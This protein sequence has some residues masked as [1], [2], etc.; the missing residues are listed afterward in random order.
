MTMDM[1]LHRAAQMT[2]KWEWQDS[3]G[4]VPGGGWALQ[5]VCFY[6]DFGW[7][8]SQRSESEVLLSPSSLSCQGSTAYGF[9]LGPEDPLQQKRIYRKLGNL[10]TIQ[11]QG[12]MRA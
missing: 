2:L 12:L 9:L 11:S 1:N 6:V 8:L 4:T 3:Q 5:I 10:P 7:T